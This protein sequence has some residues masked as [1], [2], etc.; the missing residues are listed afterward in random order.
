MQFKGLGNIAN[1]IILKLFEII[2]EWNK[3]KFVNIIIINS[4][5]NNQIPHF[6]YLF[7]LIILTAIYKLDVAYVN[8]T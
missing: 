6:T 4:T 3:S 2:G 5:A 7:I 8:V 1:D